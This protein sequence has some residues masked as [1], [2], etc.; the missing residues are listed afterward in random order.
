MRMR[1][2]PCVCATRTMEPQC[3]DLTLPESHKCG[4]PPHLINGYIVVNN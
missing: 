3:F 1:F 2:T 4:T